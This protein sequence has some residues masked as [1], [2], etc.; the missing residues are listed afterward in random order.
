MVAPSDADRSAPSETDVPIEAILHQTAIEATG[1]EDFGGPEYLPGLRAM[2]RAL[3]TDIGLSGEDLLSA[4]GPIVRGLIGRLYSQKGWK[5][6][7]SALERPI[8]APLFITGMPR[9]GTTALHHLLGWDP[10][11]QG[12]ESW[13]I[14]NPM[15]RPPRSEWEGIEHFRTAAETARAVT[16]PKRRAHWVDAHEYN[17]CQGLMLQTMVT[18]SF[19]SQRSVPSYDSWFYAQDQTPG[20]LRL[21]DQLRLIGASSDKRWLLKNPSHLLSLHALFAAFPDAR[22]VVTHRDPVEA[23]PSLC[24]LLWIMRSERRG[25]PDSDPR[26]IGR[27]ELDNWRRAL[28]SYEGVKKQ[29]SPQILDVYQRD[30]VEDPV[31]VVNLI[32]QRFEIERDGSAQALME[33]GAATPTTGQAAPEYRAEDFGLSDELIRA[34][35]VGY[36]ETYGF[37]A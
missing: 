32:Y 37:A 15:V 7:P 25:A 4:A 3:E 35:Y 6:N 34:R 12:L 8:S 23:I 19:G 9:T 13:L 11:F 14:P 31:N 17:E 33:T 28:D 30:L 24:N 29:Y 18:N 21:A 20:F 10:G 26:L 5:D 1:L 2:V 27:R 36:R 22:V 16:G